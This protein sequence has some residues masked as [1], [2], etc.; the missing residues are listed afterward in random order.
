[1]LDIEPKIYA[2]ELSDTYGRF[3][4]EPL[5][6]G[7]GHTLGAALRRVLLNYV[8]GA[9]VTAVRIDGAL[10]EF[11]TLPGVVEDTTEIIL[12]IKELAIRVK[13]DNDDG[14]PR[15]LHIDASG[16]GEVLGANVL[17][18]EDVEIVN[19]ECHIAELSEPDARLV[20][21]MWVERGRGYLQPNEM[22]RERRTLDAMPIDA[23]FSPITRVGYHVE[24][25]R[26][27]YRTDFDRLRMEI[28][29]NGTVPPNEAISIAA[30]TLHEYLIMFFDFKPSPEPE[31]PEEEPEQ[32]PPIVYT[33][34]IEDLDFSV[35]TYNC[36]KKEGIDTLGKLVQN[37]EEDLMA[38]RN[39]GRRSLNEVIEKLAQFD[40]QL[41]EPPA[42]EEDEADLDLLDEEDEED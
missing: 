16:E 25:T 32:A 30:R 9:A 29:G 38:I 22:D 17:T 3:A 19:P 6:R 5:E 37:T 40:L 21:D 36:L 1:M 35:R 41:K 15:V 11:S 4:I 10:H 24:P 28:W 8:P 12:N 2:L 33:Y 42:S 7:F 39:F 18:P 26:V 23:V 14:Q 31:E 20:I 13:S 27:G 34:R